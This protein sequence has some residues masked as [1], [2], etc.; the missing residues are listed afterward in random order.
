[1]II[2]ELVH[3][4]IVST[5]FFV[6]RREFRMVIQRLSQEQTREL[7]V[8]MDLVGRLKKCFRFFESKF[9]HAKEFNLLLLKLFI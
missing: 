4:C 8:G 6:G 3:S 1:M 9:N 7:L 2:L 5:N